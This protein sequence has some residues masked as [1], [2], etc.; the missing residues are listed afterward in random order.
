MK[1]KSMLARLESSLGHDGLIEQMVLLPEPKKSLVFVSSRAS[2]VNLVVGYSASPKSHTGLDI[3]FWIAHQT[4]LATNNLVTVHAVYVEE[5]QLDHQ[6][7]N[8]FNISSS[9]TPA[10]APSE[11]R[12]NYSYMEKSSKTATKRADKILLQAVTLAKEWEGSF[13]SHLCFGNVGTELRKIVEL[14]AADILLLGCRS[15]H[16][17]LIETLGDNFPCAVLGIPNCMDD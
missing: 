6:Y 9:M 4:H 13:K 1:I 5:N 12:P 3:A 11:F 16:H 15:V 17:P 7:L 14:V 10:L 8:V 2:C